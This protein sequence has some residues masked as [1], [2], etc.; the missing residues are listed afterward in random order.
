MLISEQIT[1][2]TLLL[3][4]EKCR[5]NIAF[6]ADKAK[7]NRVQL[8][9]H[10]KTHQ[11]LDVGEWYRDYGVSAITV[12]SVN[13]ATYFAASWEDITIAFPIN[14][15]EWRQIDKLAQSIELN[16]CAVNPE[17]V[18]SLSQQM[19]H[20]AGVFVKID[21]GYHRTGILPEET[22]ALEAT[23]KAI[24]AAPQLSFKGFMAHSGHTYNTHHSA[25][26]V[27]SIYTTAR[28]HLNYIRDTYQPSYPNMMISVGDTPGCSLLDDLSG[29][30]EIR[31]GNFCFYDLKQNY[32]GSCQ[33]DQIAVA[34]VAPVISIHPERNEVV[35]YGGGVHFSKDFLKE[36][37]QIHYGRVVEV[38][39]NGWGSPVE[40]AYVSKLSQEHG[41]IQCPDT[42]LQQKRVGDLVGI[43]PVHSCLTAD[44]MKGYLTLDNR[45]INH[46]HQC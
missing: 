40:G 10:F 22:S 15:R 41:T 38:T 37:G 12:S 46:L 1:K 30:D 32:I 4:E 31:P 14:S 39:E 19:Q 18:Q 3:D 44:L 13:M 45:H 29:F 35:F 23:I 21:V 7:K 27:A 25:E 28:Q 6:M 24:D 2:P 11:S 36:D 8:R 33:I 5:R 20:Q 42:W 9:P 17:S 43:L 16:L 34:L 26:Q